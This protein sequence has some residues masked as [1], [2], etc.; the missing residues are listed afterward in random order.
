[1]KEPKR[2][3]LRGKLSPREATKF[4]KICSLETD[5]VYTRHSW[6]SLSE[7]HVDIVN[8][9]SG[10]PASGQVHLTRKAFEKFIDWY[11]KQQRTFK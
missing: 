11:N 10:E 5:G 6:L 8:Q 3:P 2:I 4:K 9:K 1:M 7:K